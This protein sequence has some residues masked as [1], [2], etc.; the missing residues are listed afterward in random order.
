MGEPIRLDVAT[1]GLRV[2]LKVP[3]SLSHRQKNLAHRFTF[4]PFGIQMAQRLHTGHRVCLW[5]LAIRLHHSWNSTY[6]PGRGVCSSSQVTP[7]T[8]GS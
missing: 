2:A 5:V 4:F 7:S 8:P 3:G 6:P 1:H